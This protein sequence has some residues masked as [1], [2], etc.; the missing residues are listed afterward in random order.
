VVKDGKKQAVKMK[1][2]IDV[3]LKP[4]FDRKNPPLDPETGEVL[5]LDEGLTTKKFM[6][7]YAVTIHKYQGSE[8]KLIIFYLP[9]GRGSSSF[10]NRNLTYT[11]ISRA[12]KLVYVFGDIDGFFESLNKG[13]AYKHN[14][15]AARIRDKLD[16][17]NKYLAIE[18]KSLVPVNKGKQS[19]EEFI[20]EVD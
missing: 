7:S 16:E 18:N 2:V 13:P 4:K 3:P 19:M 17:K 11:A 15:L 6:L 12:R 14:T 5:E 10:I 8:G 9:F 1:R 20:S